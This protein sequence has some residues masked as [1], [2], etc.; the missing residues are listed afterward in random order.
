MAADLRG[1]TPTPRGRQ[2]GFSL[3]ELLIS[4][5]ILLI[6]TSVATSALLQLTNSQRTISNRTQLHAGV[7]SAT[8]LLQQEVGQAGRVALPGSVVTLNGAVAA[9]VGTV[10]IR[11]TIGGAASNSVAGLF[12]D[13]WL[14]VDSG[15]KAETVRIT[16]IDTAAK[17]ITADFAMPHA[18]GAA[19]NVYG[20]FAS[21]IVPDQYWNDAAWAAYPNGS[22]G[23]VLKLFGDING[24]GNMV[25]VEY[26]CDTAGGKLYRNVMAF[27]A[28][29]KPAVTD[30]E[31]LLGNITANPGGT[32][33]FTYMP[34]PLPYNINVDDPG[35][36]AN[37]NQSFVLDVAITLT[38]NT[39]QV[40]PITGQVQT[41]TKA[42][43]NVS[44]RNVFNTWQLASLGEE[45]ENRLQPMPNSVKL[46]LP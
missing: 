37:C 25:Y 15:N 36:G 14:T 30:S 40:D 10:V 11:Q 1:R 22:T 31:V 3:I 29:V 35:C 38:V 19:V 44:P 27:D 6:V 9:G 8:E 39:E 16:A 46:L 21:G 32:A 18:S 26:T 7:R 45:G 13:E 42:L 34:S 20:G 43:L 23:S 2:R 12:V 33:C 24:D 4:V 41:E 17:T 5:T 28:A